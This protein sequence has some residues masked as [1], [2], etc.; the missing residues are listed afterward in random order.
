MQTPASMITTSGDLGGQK[1][2]MTIDQSAMAHIMSILTD[3]Y[4]DPLGAVIREY[5]TNARD[6]HIEAGN[7]APIEIHTPSGFSPFLKII[8]HG[9][10]LSVDDIERIYSQYGASTKRDTNEQTGMLGLGAKSALTL[11]PQFNL[12]SVKNGV[13][14]LVSVSRSGDGG[15]QM[16]IVD[17][18]A[19]DEPNGVEIS[20]PYSNSYLLRDKIK[21]F[22]RFW[23]AGSVLVDGIE[24][25]R[26]QGEEIGDKF[27][28][29]G[30][31]RDYVVMG[32]VAYPVKG[33]GL[34]KTN[35]YQMGIVAFVEIGDVNFTPSRE[36]LQYTQT[37]MATLDRLRAEFETE[38]NKK[39]TADIQNAKTWHEAW[40]QQ[41]KWRARFPN[42][43][44]QYK[45]E[46]L[47]GKT[48][49]T[50]KSKSWRMRSGRSSYYSAI[51]AVHPDDSQDNLYVLNFANSDL[52]ASPTMRKKGEAYC[53]QKGLNL[54]YM[55]LINEGSIAADSAMDKYLTSFHTVDWAELNKIKIARKV[56]AT[57]MVR[58]DPY[59]RVYADGSMTQVSSFDVTKPIIYYS[60]A[61]LKNPRWIFKMIPDAQVVELPRNRWGKF[62]RDWPTAKGYHAAV[63]DATKGIAASLTEADRIYHHYASRLY[64]FGHVADPDALDDPDLKAF[65]KALNNGASSRVQAYQSIPGGYPKPEVAKPD[66]PLTKYPLGDSL[67]SVPETH[68][69]WYLNT[70]YA[71]WKKDN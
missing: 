47:P 70:Y 22:F 6:A 71:E 50:H 67:R 56:S 16:E 1:I 64:Y 2:Q 32:G 24:P 27:I 65:C 57:G 30:D 62:C 39:I 33:D 14:I 7:T 5:S 10:G 48:I 42:A 28:I 19:T 11:V 55:V 26:I 46:D 43:R 8:D 25:Q 52:K 20:I 4:S 61:D 23:P 41:N 13:K 9:V 38:V 29:T 17:T 59:D 53:Q 12:T 35:M 36:D 3:L 45:G 51:N 21:N 37:T 63:L 60:P 34:Y 54:T 69:I 31:N 66:N 44:A 15:G 68:K 49:E 18:R 40:S 58:T